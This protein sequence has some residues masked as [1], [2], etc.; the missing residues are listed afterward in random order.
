MET[1]KIGNR[2]TGIIRACHTG[3]L[4]TTEMTYDNQPY[5]IFKGAQATLSF[6]VSSRN[7]TNGQRN[8]VLGYNQTF[9][10][11]LIVSDVKLTDK[12]MS[13]IYMKKEANLLCSA[14]KEKTSDKNCKIYFDDSLD[15]RYQVFV[16]DVNGQLIAA[17]GTVVGNEFTITNAEP[18]TDYLVI[19][20]YLGSTTYD[21]SSA[22]NIYIALDLIIE[23][24]KDDTSQPMFIHL[25]KC[26]LRPNK[27]LRFTQITNTV[28]LTF[29]IIKSDDNVIVIE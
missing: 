10:Q 22:E 12:I 29:E 13:L 1:Y 18:F 15:E 11:E 8:T 27:N 26:N 14:V 25:A 24:S 21:L 17:E 28:D 5:T 7:M 16:Y 2:V 6:S 19:Y 4:G 20:N 3:T 23:G 9:P